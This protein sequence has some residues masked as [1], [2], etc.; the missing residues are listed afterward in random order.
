V[1]SLFRRQ[2]ITVLNLEQPRQIVSLSADKITAGTIYVRSAAQA[3]QNCAA[4]KHAQE[5]REER[6]AQ[7]KELVETDRLQRW[8]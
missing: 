8:S 6:E 3:E 4:I 1:F 7:L 5:L 2:P